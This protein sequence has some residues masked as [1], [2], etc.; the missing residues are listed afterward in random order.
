M[1]RADQQFFALLRAG[2]W[3]KP[4]EENLFSE[5]FDSNII[6]KMASMQTVSGIL[7]DGISKLPIDKQ[8][9]T[10]LMR[11]L[12][13]TTLR[14]E[15][16]HELLNNTIEKI[17]PALQKEGVRPIL[18]KGQ[19]VAQNYPNPLRRQCG[20]IDLYVGQKD[21]EKA[22]GI[23]LS[24]GAEPE[25]KTKK[26]S[27]KHENFYLNDVGVELHFLAEKLRNPFLNPRFQ[28]WT[29]KYL[30][31]NELRIWTLDNTNIY[32][33]PANFDALYIFNHA[34]HHFISAGVGLRQLCDWMLYLHRFKDRINR[35]DLLRDLKNLNLLRPWQIFGCIVVNQLGLPKEDFPFYTSEYEKISK[36]VLYLI[37]QVGNFGF[38]HLNDKEHP[39][40][41][42]S[43]KFN[44]LLFKQK[45]VRTVFC[46]FPK[47]VSIFY[48][49]YC[50]NGISNI[51]RGV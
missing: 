3:D 28:R 43:G 2:L 36:R 40:G 17:V 34:F 46:L 51:I 45:W 26:K 13:Q 5:S 20:D 15:Q 30:R 49:W 18:L 6:L 16:S 24:I 23:L 21:C 50:C 44:S 39:T 11:K 38:Y 1:N 35:D 14:I 31:G 9:P 22:M 47:D 29:Q 4:I 32:L 41:F 19:G 33:P 10:S 48:I 27:P 25:N 37:M 7:F 42:L 8:P 12:Y